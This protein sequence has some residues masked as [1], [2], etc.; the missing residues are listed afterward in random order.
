MDIDPSGPAA[1]VSGGEASRVDIGEVS[2]A[3]IIPTPSTESALPKSR[4]PGRSAP[5]PRTLRAR[6]STSAPAASSASP[7][8]KLSASSVRPP[9][10][11]ESLLISRKLGPEAL[12]TRRDELLRDKEQELRVVVDEHDTVVREKFHLEKYILMIT[13]WDPEVSSSVNS[14]SVS[15]SRRCRLLKPTTRPSS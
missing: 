11:K 13:G 1:E 3:E 9:T 5:A 2:G 10:E 6:P 14:E 12:Q 8:S 7:S 4:P 15:D